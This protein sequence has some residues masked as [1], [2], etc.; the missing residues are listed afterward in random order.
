MMI[1]MVL[2]MSV[3]VGSRESVGVAYH[4]NVGVAKHGNV[5][6]VEVVSGVGRTGA[7]ACPCGST[8]PASLTSV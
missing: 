4:H 3:E 7:T 6:V 8:R 2:V 1:E 5:G